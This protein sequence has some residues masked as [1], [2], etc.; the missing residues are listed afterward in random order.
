[1]VMRFGTW[2]IRSFYRVGSLMTVSRES[3]RYRL[4][5]VGMLEV[6]WEGNGTAP[7]GE[8]TFCY[9]KGNEIHELGIG[10]LVC[11]GIMSAAMRVEFVSDRSCIIL[12]CCWFHIIVLNVHTPNRG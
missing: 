3:S 5:I 2:N 9:G 1:M 10:F 6:R 8:Y 4:N 12:K 7:A 11:K